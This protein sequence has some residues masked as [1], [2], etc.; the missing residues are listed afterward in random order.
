MIANWIKGW[1]LT[2][3]T[4]DG[5]PVSE[6]A[7]PYTLSIKYTDAISRLGCVNNS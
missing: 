3:N 1:S 7:Q 4:M 2:A 5:T 6:F